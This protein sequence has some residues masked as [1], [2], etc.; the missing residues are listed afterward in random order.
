VSE[1]R[2]IGFTILELLVAM[3]VTSLLVV[4]LLQ[5]IGI[6]SSRWKSVNDK[7]QSYSSARA[8][9]DAFT[10]SLA[11]AT[12]NTE[13]DYYNTARQSR[14]TL[15]ANSDTAGLA[16]FTPDLYGRSS[17]L[18]FISGKSLVNNQHTHAV[19]FQ[20][21]LDF[22]TSV[23]PQTLS[24]QLNAIGYFIRFGDDAAGR[25]PNISSSNPP[26]K[27]RFRL[28][29][30]LQPTTGLDTYRETAGSGWFTND[31]NASPPANQ[32]VLAENIVVLAVMPRLPDGT[33]AP[34]YEYDSRRQWGAGAAQPVQMHQLPPVVR[35]LMVVID[36]T[37]AARDPSLGSQFS[38]LF[39][40]PAQYD[41]NI[42]TVETTLR[43]ARAEY[44]IF[45]ADVPL[46]AAKWSE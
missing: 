10:R 13:Y 39:Q 12:L 24:G 46:R 5:I 28:M 16:S 26:P 17:A 7:A 34:N 15:T 40:D 27:N 4:M 3:A 20:A 2:N 44:Q 9:F 25:P 14:L 31:V 11:Q 6:S 22:D 32:H 35:V 18:H 38:G 21:P 23:P 29:Q 30:Y 19:F 45:Q 1:H 42:A 37:S 43:D 8:A 41:A 36:E 33:A